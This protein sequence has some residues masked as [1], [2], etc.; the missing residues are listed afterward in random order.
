MLAC[1]RL[2]AP[3]TVVFGGFSADALRD[4]INDAGCKVVITADGGWR[5]GQIVPLKA[6]STAL[7]SCPACRTGAGGEAH[8]PA[9][10]HGPRAT[11]GGSDALVARASTHEAPALDAEHP[12][13]ILYT[14]GSTGKPKGVLHTTGGYLVGTGAHHEARLR[15]RDDDVY[16]C[17]A[18]VG[19]DHR[20]QLRGV[21]PA[22][23]RR[24]RADVRGRAQ[25]ARSGTA[26]G[27]LI[28]R[29]GVSILYTAP[30]AIRA[31]MKWGDEHPRAHDSRRCACWAR[32]ASPSTPRPGCGTTSVI[33]G[34][35]CPI[36]DTWWQTETG[37]IMITPLPGR[38]GH[39]ARLVPRARSSASR[40]DVV[41]DNGTPAAPQRGRPPGDQAR[42]RPCCARSGATTRATRPPTSRASTASTS[43]A[44]AR[45]ATRTA[46]S[47]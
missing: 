18:D 27:R 39:Q 9:R 22:L 38:H 20:P 41:R 19:L 17:T 11:T 12:L 34:E 47:G 6:P 36:V 2:G 7:P 30:T 45:A 31:F 8:R 24:H 13:F 43:P 42:G 28:E 21:R 25:P 35:R 26:S 14:S 3:H 5:R 37:A 1:A 15:P 32:W 46:T 44:T 29:H 16:W 23:L 10:E 33:G 4:R 40:A